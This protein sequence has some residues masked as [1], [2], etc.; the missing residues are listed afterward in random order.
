MR[1]LNNLDHG[2][3]RGRWPFQFLPYLTRQHKGT[4]CD[5]EDSRNA[6]DEILELGPGTL[7]VLH[8][9]SQVHP[10]MSRAYRLVKR[11]YEGDRT[12]QPEFAQRLGHL[13]CAL[14]QEVPKARVHVVVIL[15]L[16]L[17][18]LDQLPNML[19]LSAGQ[20]LLRPVPVEDV[21]AML[22]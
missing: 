6:N 8:P 7:V 1:C 12:T 5:L 17:K 16:I 18:L 20:H 2:S 21:A 9:D 15:N 10:A 13:K 11:V 19:Q 22:Q 4:G 14:E 3:L